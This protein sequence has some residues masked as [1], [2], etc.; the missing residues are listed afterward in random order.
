LAERKTLFAADILKVIYAPHKAFKSIIQNPKYTGPILIV[1]L[2]IAAS[3][4]STYVL[5][6]KTY[7]EKTM[8]DWKLLDQWTENSTLWTSNLSTQITESNDSLSGVYYG[9][10]SIAF[11]LSDNTE[12]WAE[13]KDIGPV[14]C[15][16][17]QGYSNVSFRMKWTSP[18]TKP[19]NASIQLFSAGSSEY[20]YDNLTEV[21]SNFSDNVWNNV[22]LQLASSDWSSSST[23]ANWDNITGLK[24]DF[25]WTNSSNITLLVDGLFFRGVFESL[26]ESTATSDLIT[27]AFSWFTQ[28]LL[29]WVILTGLVY[30]MIRGFRGSVIWKP[31]L[32]VI[33]FVMVTMVVQ[34]FVNMAAYLGSPTVHYPLELIGGVAGES[35]VAYNAIL[36]QTW[37]TY[38]IMSYTRIAVY[39][40]TMALCSLAAHILTGFNWTKSLLIGTVAYL[41]TLL[42]ASFL[43][44]F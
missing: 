14:N 30:L 42:A 25:T 29:V 37:L 1:I 3:M 9:N 22:T 43:V 2:F 20:F 27:Y 41:I 16:E 28:I 17:R 36:E 6:S 32:I 15:S 13:L 34:S 38:Q 35:N 40:W 23:A 24:L 39:L 12:V 11:S 21:I 7:L 4:G 44:G 33:G 18:Q 8:P 31:I 5:I 19:A 26:L 10:R